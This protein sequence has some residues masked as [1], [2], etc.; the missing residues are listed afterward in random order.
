MAPDVTLEE[1][2]GL[3]RAMTYKNAAAGLPHGGAK[4]VIAADPQMPTAEKEALI[5]A[6]ARGLREIVS[7]IPGPDMGTNEECMA[8]IR[9]EVGRSIGLPM[10][11]GGIPLDEIGATGFGLAIAAEVAENYC[12]VRLKGARVAVQGYGAVGYHAARFLVERGAVLVAAADSGGMI[13]NPDGLDVEALRRLSLSGGSI[14]DHSEGQR[15]ER[16][17]IV[18]VDCDIWIPAARPNVLTAANVGDVKAKLILQGANIPA[19]PDA[20]AGLHERGILNVPDFVANAGGVICGS[21]E[22][23]GGTETGAFA[24]IREK[25]ERNTDE[26]LSRAKQS[27]AAP[28]AAAEAMAR[29]RIERAMSFRRSR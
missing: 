24:A 21:V 29:E 28:R 10:E 8:W 6:F 14:G 23:H 2:F 9:D 13:A 11:L 12:D 4:S 27:N 15:H 22:Y 16:D 18:A 7:Y 3:A 1:C 25:I 20:E 19:T 17:A 5:R 26:S